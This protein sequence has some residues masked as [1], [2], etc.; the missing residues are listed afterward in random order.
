MQR[1][2]AFA[3][4]TFDKAGK[5]EGDPEVLFHGSREED[6]RSFGDQ[7]QVEI[8]VLQSSKFRLVCDPLYHR[9]HQEYPE[10]RIRLRTAYDVWDFSL[11]ASHEDGAQETDRIPHGRYVIKVESISFDDN[12]VDATLRLLLAQKGWKPPIVDAVKTSTMTLRERPQPRSTASAFTFDL[13]LSASASDNLLH[14]NHDQVRGLVW[15][16]VHQNS[17]PAQ[18]GISPERKRQRLSMPSDGPE[19]LEPIE[20]VSRSTI[21]GGGTSRVLAATATRHERPDS[22]PAPSAVSSVACVMKPNDDRSEQAREWGH[23]D[24]ATLVKSIIFGASFA[25]AANTLKCSE[26]SAKSEFA[27]LMSQESWQTIAA[28]LQRRRPL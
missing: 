21:A 10:N 28:D 4:Q 14:V 20:S 15:K 11:E 23:D 22:L 9:D 24:H 8:K 16:R 17:Q 13:P 7:R 26:H 27:D 2:S 3:V 5:P 12:G 1:G 19:A 25:E 18:N 6:A